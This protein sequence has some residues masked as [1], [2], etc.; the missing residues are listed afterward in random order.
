MLFKITNL[1]GAIVKNLS[2]FDGLWSGPPFLLIS[3][4]YFGEK[5][6]D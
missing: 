4:N 5:C 1:I 6:F 2:T 3:V